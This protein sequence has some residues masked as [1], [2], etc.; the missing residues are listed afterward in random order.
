MT[1][2]DL[3]LNIANVCVLA[4][5]SVRDILKLPAE[6]RVIGHNDASRNTED[7]RLMSACRHHIIANSTFSWWGAWLNRRTDKIVVAPSR[8][9]AD[10]DHVN[11]DI[12]AEGWTRID[13]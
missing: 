10:P 1:T 8:W 4:S 6:M 5:F 9:F 11:P 12:W 2:G 3:L 13:S 7:L